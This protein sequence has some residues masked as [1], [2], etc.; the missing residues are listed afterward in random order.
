MCRITNCTSGILPPL[1]KSRRHHRRYV[2]ITTISRAA[3]YRV[4][5]TVSPKLYGAY[6]NISNSVRRNVA[7]TYVVFK[8]T[9]HAISMFIFKN[10]TGRFS[11]SNCA[12]Q[13]QSAQSLALPDWHDGGDSMSSYRS[14][15]AEHYIYI[16]SR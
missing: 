4:W 2:A 15:F 5:L 9:K 16:G 8:L 12:R 11:S 13:K 7:V 1:L 14:S 3:A 10:R 6:P